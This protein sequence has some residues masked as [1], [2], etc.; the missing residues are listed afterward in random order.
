MTTDP[1]SARCVI[2]IVA[3]KTD[4]AFFLNKSFLFRETAV[5]TPLINPPLCNPPPQHSPIPSCLVFLGS[6]VCMPI[7]GSVYSP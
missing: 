5:I 1:E 6:F 2:L 7:N 3:D 4:E